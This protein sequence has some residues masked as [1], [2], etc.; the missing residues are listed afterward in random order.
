MQQQDSSTHIHTSSVHY[1]GNT[2]KI[3]HFGWMICRQ[4]DAEF[5]GTLVLFWWMLVIYERSHCVLYLSLFFKKS[6]VQ[7]CR[8]LI[9]VKWWER[10]ESFIATLSE[11]VSQTMLESAE[12]TLKWISKHCDQEKRSLTSSLSSTKLNLAAAMGSHD[13]VRLTQRQCFW[14]YIWSNT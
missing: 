9:W 13:T 3:L 2:D 5:H 7:F 1:W 11:L 14:S 10:F 8:V 6:L 4:R 12:V